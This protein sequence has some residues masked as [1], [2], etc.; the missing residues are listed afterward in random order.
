MGG[1]IANSLFTK[2]GTR[3]CDNFIIDE[4]NGLLLGKSPAFDNGGMQ[5]LSRTIDCN[6]KNGVEL[7]TKG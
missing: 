1:G 2:N 4:A 7:W 6:G 3:P 5:G